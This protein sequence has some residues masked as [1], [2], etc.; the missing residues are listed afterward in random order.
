MDFTIF[1]AWQSDRPQN[2]NRY[3]IRDAAKEAVARSL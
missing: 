2:A 3:L 1:Y